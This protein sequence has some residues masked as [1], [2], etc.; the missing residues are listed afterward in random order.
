MVA[1]PIGYRCPDCARG[2]TPAIYQASAS[3][4]ATGAALGITIA[5]LVGVFWGIFPDWEFYWTLVLGFGVSESISWA[6]KY[7]RGT[8]L[9][10]VAMACV[11]LGI[12]LARVVMAWDSPFLTLDMLLNE[13]TEPGVAEA[14]QLE[15]I[16]DFLFMAIPFVI[17]YIRFK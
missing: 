4:I 16:P 12:I 6:V 2:P 7:K 5:S 3:G 1:T 15:L 8:E 17:N 14:F 9:M 13:T 10:V 11:V